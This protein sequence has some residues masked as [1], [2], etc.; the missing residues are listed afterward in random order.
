MSH[1][2]TFTLEF[3]YLK[4]QL[5]R[6]TKWL[7]Q[8]CVVGHFLLL[9]NT[10]LCTVHCVYPDSNL[11]LISYRK[12]R[13]CCRTCFQTQERKRERGLS[14]CLL[15]Y[16]IQFSY[17]KVCLDT[18]VVGSVGSSGPTVRYPGVPLSIVA[19]QAR[20]SFQRK[21]VAGKMIIRLVAAKF[22][23]A[24]I[25]EKRAFPQLKRGKKESN[26]DSHERPMETIF[27]WFV[28]PNGIQ[29][30]YHRNTN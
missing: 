25:G 12:W 11:V 10:V 3:A 13:K 28:L 4:H 29:S 16:Q 22:D 23:A 30:R 27:C 18:W 26:G 20:I 9:Q 1:R 6:L 21:L 17:L 7:L 19:S 2:G 5:S 14:P 24:S 15:S 8:N